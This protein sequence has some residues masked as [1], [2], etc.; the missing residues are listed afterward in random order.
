M[1]DSVRDEGVVLPLDARGE[2]D[3]GLQE[4]VLNGA[5]ILFTGGLRE[6]LLV[7]CLTEVDDGKGPVRCFPVDKGDG[8]LEAVLEGY[9]L[10]GPAP[11]VLH[12]Q[13]D[14]RVLPQPGDDTRPD[15]VSP[16]DPEEDRGGIDVL[17]F[18]AVTFFTDDGDTVRVE[19]RHG[20]YRFLGLRG[21]GRRPP[22]AWSG[23]MTLSGTD[24]R[25]MSVTNI[26]GN[27][28]LEIRFPSCT[29]KLSTGPFRR[30]RKH[31]PLSAGKILMMSLSMAA[32]SF[33]ILNVRPAGPLR[34][35][36]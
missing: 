3:D 6:L 33:Y 26:A 17:L 5:G 28:E 24:S 13:D 36:K 20:R 21:S 31:L 27:R 1:A 15:P 9:P 14:R 30:G 22:D 29:K 25:G 32:C 16:G 2:V 4:V 8:H 7:D 19:Y 18:V 10:V 35:T 23:E 12:D 11:A 34:D